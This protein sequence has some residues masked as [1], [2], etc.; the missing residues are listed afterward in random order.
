MG[1]RV[2]ARLRQDGIEPLAF[3]DNRES[4]WGKT[5]DGLPVLSPDEATRRHG[6]DAAFI[7]TIYNHNHSFSDT[8]TQLT[9]LGCAKVVSVVLL[10]WKY[11]EAFLPYFRDDLPHKV[12]L[13]ATEIREAFRLWADEASRR[14]FVAQI[15]WRLCADFD[16]LGLPLWE[17]A[18]FPQD[19]FQFA[20][21]DFFVDVGAYDGDTV[22]KFLAA[23]GNQFERILALEPDPGSFKRLID[24]LAN[25]PLSLRSRIE[26]RALAVGAEACRVRFASG[27]ETSSAFSERGSIEVECVRID[28]LLDA[29]QP[30]Y[31]KMD[32]EGAELDA[33]AGGR[34]ILA[35]QTPVVA[36]CV[37][38]AQDHLWKIPLALREISS[39]YRFFL[40][41]YM[42]EC[43]ETV[44]YAVPAGRLVCETT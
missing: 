44:C 5:L 32:I 31:I 23:R 33:I 40:R 17:Q 29:Q 30:T 38:H 7:V 20:Q 19:I 36:A 16:R 22:R 3:S 14:E 4:N 18:Y 28:D 35:Q 21:D 34:N 27:Q 41:P 11:Q 12:L 1:R 39:S 15:R 24:Y 42:A 43:W 9:A 8:R 10:R 26:A 13:Q 2:L 25:L 6:R 37:Y